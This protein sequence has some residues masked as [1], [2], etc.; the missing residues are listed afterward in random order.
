LTYSS[1]TSFRYCHK[2]VFI[3][4]TRRQLFGQITQLMLKLT[5]FHLSFLNQGSFIWCQLSKALILNPI[6]WRNTKSS[7]LKFHETCIKLIFILTHRLERS[8]SP[9]YHRVITAGVNFTNPLVQNAN[10]PVHWV[11][12]NQFTNKIV[13]SFKSL[14]NYCSSFYNLCS[15]LCFS[16]FFGSRHPLEST[17]NWRH[18]WLAKNGNLRHF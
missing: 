18:P 10:V 3:L 7:Q 6:I 13:L 8:R 15:T 14:H 2:I 9:L 12:W 4:I 11:W 16:T 17:K 5:L 1:I